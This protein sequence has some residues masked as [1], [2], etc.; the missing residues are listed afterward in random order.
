MPLIDIANNAFC[1]I[2]DFDKNKIKK[3]HNL[4]IRHF[5][6]SN[7]NRCIA[8]SL[9][10]IHQF[11]VNR[12]ENKPYFENGC[13]IVWSRDDNDNKAY[14][15]LKIAIMKH[16]NKQIKKLKRKINRNREI[17]KSF[18]KLKKKAKNDVSY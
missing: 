9:N 11:F 1:W 18:K 13:C 14:N 17:Q 5:G 2:Y 10:E 4:T 15:C 16:T 6:F 8:F 3:Y 12:Y 7:E